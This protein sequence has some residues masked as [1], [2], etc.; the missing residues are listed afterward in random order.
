MRYPT[1][2]CVLMFPKVLLFKKSD[3]VLIDGRDDVVDQV[4]VVELLIFREQQATRKAMTR[5][6]EVDGAF[7]ICASAVEVFDIEELNLLLYIFLNEL[8]GQ[9]I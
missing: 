8:F 5:I 3:R 1:V 4:F 6:V 2:I 9:T 7:R